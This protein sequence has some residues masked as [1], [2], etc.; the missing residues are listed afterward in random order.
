YGAR[1]LIQGQHGYREAGPEG[2]STQA[3]RDGASQA[4]PAAVAR[5]GRGGRAQATVELYLP[6]CRGASFEL[7]PGL[8]GTRHRGLFCSARKYAACFG[9]TAICRRPAGECTCRVRRAPRGR[10]TFQA[11]SKQT[12]GA[13]GCASFSRTSPWI[14]GFAFWTSAAPRKPTSTSSPCGATSCTRKTCLW[15]WMSLSV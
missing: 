12:A 8:P 13:T 7:A 4:R 1:R 10:L 2:R 14:A 5:G 15:G 6:A 9:Q 3:C 11:W